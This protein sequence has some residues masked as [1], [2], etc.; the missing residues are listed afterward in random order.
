MSQGSES[1]SGLRIAL[2]D[3]DE[4]VHHLFFV[5]PGNEESLVDFLY[6]LLEIYGEQGEGI[7]MQI[8]GVEAF[9]RAVLGA[10]V[11]EG[12]LVR[13][14]DAEYSLADYPLPQ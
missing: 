9:T 14:G 7:A 13:V 1:R 4:N 5:D 12:A 6:S 11:E 3:P 8:L 10:L 2:P